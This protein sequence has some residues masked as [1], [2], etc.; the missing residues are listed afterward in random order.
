[1][2]IENDKIGVG[3]VNV[4]PRLIIFLTQ[5]HSQ[6][7]HSYPNKTQLVNIKKYNVRQLFDYH[8]DLRGRNIQFAW[9]LDVKTAARGGGNS[10]K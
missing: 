5:I 4:R 10:R 8:K 3:H 2:Y 6:K 9:I 7:A 1:M